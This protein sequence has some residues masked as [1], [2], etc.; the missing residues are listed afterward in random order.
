MNAHRIAV[1]GLGAIGTRVLRT[2]QDE[3][4]PN[5]TY[6]AFDRGF[7]A[8]SRPDIRNV[9]QCSAVEA[10]HDWRPD[11]AIECAGHSLVASV[12]PELLCR[13]AD[14]IIASIGALVDDDLRERLRHAALAGR[15]RLMT[16]SG[17]VGGLDAL[18]AAR[19]SG[20]Q[21]VVYTGRKPPSAWRGT[22]ADELVDLSCIETPTMLFLGS[23]RGAASR[24][25]Q[26]ANVTAAIALAGVGFDR[27]D[28]RLIADPTID[29][30]IHEIDVRGGFGSF[31]V[32]FENNPLAENPK[33]SWLAVLS[34]EQELRKYLALNQAPLRSTDAVSGSVDIPQ[35]ERPT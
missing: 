22:P 2:L 13:G 10:L 18:A 26:N 28:V 21:A 27:T 31:S 14:V 9:E 16:V 24:Y 15:S 4:L 29:R 1:L 30:N 17:A 25:P 6:A 8:G 7:G 19:G 3:I 20:L 11:L 34:I 5:A 23:A 35:S 12:V 33:T 32:R